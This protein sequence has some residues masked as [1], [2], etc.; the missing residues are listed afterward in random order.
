MGNLLLPI[1]VLHWHYQ[2]GLGF[3]IPSIDE[4]RFNYLSSHEEFENGMKVTPTEKIC[5]LVST[6][7]CVRHSRKFSPM[8]Y[9]QHQIDP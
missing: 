5:G 3:W 7:F 2:S 4:D 9:L 6:L 1:A 8:E